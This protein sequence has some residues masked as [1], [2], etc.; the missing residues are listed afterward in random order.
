MRTSRAIVVERAVLDSYHKLLT[1]LPGLPAI[2][3][4]GQHAFDKRRK[5]IR[6]SAPGYSHYKE[7]FGWQSSRCQQTI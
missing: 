7:A 5:K 2:T 6:P 1:L 3:H 4:R